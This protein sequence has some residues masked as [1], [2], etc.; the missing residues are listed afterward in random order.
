MISAQDER[1]REQIDAEMGDGG[2]DSETLSL[3]RRV[4]LFGKQQPLRKKR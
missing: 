4:V 2:D 1:P 3:K